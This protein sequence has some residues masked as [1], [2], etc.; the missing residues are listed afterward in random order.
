MLECSLDGKF[1][2]SKY[3]WWDTGDGF[4]HEDLVTFISSYPAE[5]EQRNSAEI[6]IVFKKYLTTKLFTSIGNNFFYKFS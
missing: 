2:S 1:A 6:N 4:S 5:D 3:L